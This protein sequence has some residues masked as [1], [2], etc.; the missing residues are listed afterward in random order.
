MLAGCTIGAWRKESNSRCCVADSPAYTTSSSL[1][2]RLL[3]GSISL[4]GRESSRSSL[5]TIKK[6]K[7]LEVKLLSLSFKRKE[8]NYLL[9]L[10]G[11]DY[12]VS[13]ILYR[14]CL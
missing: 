2:I 12:V 11:L 7:D 10:L 1:I 8:K 13:L 9:F 3:L 6:L 5:I 4:R 14:L